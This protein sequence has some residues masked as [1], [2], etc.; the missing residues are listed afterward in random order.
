MQTIEE[1]AG[2]ID[3]QG[4]DDGVWIGAGQSAAAGA[5]APRVVLNAQ[6]ASAIFQLRPNP[7]SSDGEPQLATAK[8]VAK[9]FGVS[10]KTVR[11]IW[12]ARTWAHATCHLDSTR[13]PPVFKRIGRPPNSSKKHAQASRP[14]KTIEEGLEITEEHPFASCESSIH[15]EIG[16]QDQLSPRAE[17]ES[18]SSHGGTR[19]LQESVDWLLGEWDSG[20]CQFESLRDPFQED[21][22]DDV[23]SRPASEAPGLTHSLPRARGCQRADRP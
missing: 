17:T 21:G 9:A 6:Q 19:D 20:A 18:S 15:S 11:D 16:R 10:P 8:V 2:Q 3:A 1:E 4:W 14:L 22:E 23:S 12:H 5:R 13:P 7:D